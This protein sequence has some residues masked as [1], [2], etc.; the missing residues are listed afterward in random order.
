MDRTQCSMWVAAPRARGPL[1]AGWRLHL[2]DERIQ[3]PPR[4]TIGLN[5]CHPLLR[6]NQWL[7]MLSTGTKSEMANMWV[8]WLSNPGPKVDTP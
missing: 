8:Y 3:H 4:A 6:R 1:S 7:P 5:K 2:H